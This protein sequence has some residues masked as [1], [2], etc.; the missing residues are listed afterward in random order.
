MQCSSTVTKARAAIAA[1]KAAGTNPDESAA[2]RAFQDAVNAIEE[3]ARVY[4]VRL[5]TVLH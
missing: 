3:C 4:R 5:L 2:V 1:A